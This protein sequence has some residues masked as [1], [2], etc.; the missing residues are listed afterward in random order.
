MFDIKLPPF[1]NVVCKRL[2]AYYYLRLSAGCLNN[3]G[4]SILYFGLHFNMLLIN[5]SV[6]FDILLIF[7]G[8][9]MSPFSII[10]T[11]YVIFAALKGGLNK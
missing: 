7:F 8:K 4:Q 2:A 6:C 10:L 3:Y 1:P 9:F 11:N 5:S